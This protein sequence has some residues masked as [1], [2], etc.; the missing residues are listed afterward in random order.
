MARAGPAVSLVDHKEGSGVDAK[1]EL[2]DTI[3]R[4]VIG[5]WPLWCVVA[6][7]AV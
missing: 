4:C 5:V 1:L 6:P 7:W 2:I 3:S